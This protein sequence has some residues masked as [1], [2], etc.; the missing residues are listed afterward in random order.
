MKSLVAATWTQRST[1]PRA[2]PAGLVEVRHLGPSTARGRWPGS[3]RACPRRRAA[4]RPATRWTPARR[5]SR[6]SPRRHGRPAGADGPA[7]RRPAP[8]PPARNRSGHWPGRERRGGHRPAPTGP[9]LRPVLDRHQLDPR[10]VEHLPPVFTDHGRTGQV[11]AATAAFPGTCT[12]TWSGSGR[13]SNRNLWSPRCLRP[14]ARRSDRGGGFTNASELGGFD[15]FCEFLPS[16][17]SNCVTRVEN[18]T[19]CADN[20]TISRSPSAS[21]ASRSA[22]S[23]NSC[24]TLGAVGTGDTG[25]ESPATSTRLRG[26]SQSRTPQASRSTASD[27]AAAPTTWIVTALQQSMRARRR[28]PLL[29]QVGGRAGCVSLTRTASFGLRMLKQGS[30]RRIEDVD[31]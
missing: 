19:T 8:Q 28:R 16:R 29:R 12:T 9:P 31:L 18:S 5:S 20:S 25:D 4:A 22:S 24:S 10:Q 14:D 30:P 13:G 11:P 21:T 27:Q 26:K 1:A 2:P 3:R 15:E 23:T 7:G 17:A 6:P